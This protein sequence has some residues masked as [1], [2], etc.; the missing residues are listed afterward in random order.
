MLRLTARWAQEWNTWGDPG[1]VGR[2][3]ERFVTACESVGRDPKSMHRS[4]QALV[5]YAPTAA[6]RTAME[7]HVVANRSLIGGTQELI[8]QLAQYAELGVD[9][10]AIADF[11]LGETS[12]Q[13]RETYEALH[14]EVLSAFR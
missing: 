1:E 7:P 4:A 11:T 10:F 13:R 5:F 6:A 8:D 2:R 14:A 3:T 12:E 9:E